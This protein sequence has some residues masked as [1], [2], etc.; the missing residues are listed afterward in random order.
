MMIKRTPQRA[1]CFEQSQTDAIRV[2]RIGA[3]WK[4][5]D[6]ISFQI[7]YGILCKFAKNSSKLI[8]ENFN[9]PVS[10]HRFLNNSLSKYKF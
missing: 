3:D 9:M 2:R 4:Q 10:N 5:I 8:R 6:H 1:S 7:F